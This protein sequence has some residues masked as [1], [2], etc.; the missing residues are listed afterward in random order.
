MLTGCPTGLGA[1]KLIKITEEYNAVIVCR[2]SCTGIK[3]VDA[4]VDE[5]KP[6]L[7]HSAKVF[8]I[9]LFLHDTQ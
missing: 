3:S 9:A 8:P 6:P 5:E 7:S 1:D 2:E 4:L